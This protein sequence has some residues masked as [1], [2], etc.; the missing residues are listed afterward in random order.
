MNSSFITHPNLIGASVSHDVFG[1][2]EL[3]SPQTIVAVAASE[4]GLVVYTRDNRGYVYK[5]DFD[6]CIVKF[7]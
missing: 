4:T 3:D 2:R 5:R 6:G 1:G 7:N